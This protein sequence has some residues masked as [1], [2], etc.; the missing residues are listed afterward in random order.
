MNTDISVAILAGLGGMLGW[1]IGDFFAKKTIDAIGDIPSLFWAH[2]CGVLIFIVVGLY[3]RG[4]A[5][6]HVSSSATTWLLL[7]F[8][9]VLQAIVYLLLYK[10]FSKGQV[11]VLN[12]L[13]SSFTGIVALCS[14]IVFGEMV[15][16]H[17][18]IALLVIFAG[19]I[20]LNLNLDQIHLGKASFLKVPGFAEVACATLCAAVWTMSWD[21]FIKGH[22]W[23]SYAVW[24]YLFMTLAIFAMARYQKTN[25]RVARMSIWKYLVLIGIC[26][27]VAY[28]AISWG[29]ST[30]VHTSI[31]ALMSGAFSL[32]T[33]ILARLILKE[34]TVRT[35][36]VGSIAI[37]VGIV[38]LSL[39]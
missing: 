4:N 28:Y 37:I 27:M 39:A 12:P 17:L 29:Y 14:I 1:G 30:N 36:L 5:L 9:G 11:A 7:I 23:L 18:V 31:I 25:L 15:S 21:K 20:L 35:Q 34:K 38:I 8:F 19:I 6:F 13:F 24:M 26:E 10:G 3:V 22:D 33:I 16:G 2:L 32:P